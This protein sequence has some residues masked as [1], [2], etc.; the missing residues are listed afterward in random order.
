MTG[1]STNRRIWLVV[2]LCGLVLLAG[3]QGPSQLFGSSDEVSTERPT[4]QSP[5]TPT[6][7]ATPNQSTAETAPATPV[8]TT[9]PTR[10]DGNE[11]FDPSAFRTAFR[12]DIADARETRGVTPL[13]VAPEQRQVTDTIARELAEAGYF[14]NATAQNSSRFDVRSRL[15]RAELSCSAATADGQPVGGGFLL[16][17]FYRTYIETDGNITYYETESQLARSMTTR[18][19]TTNSTAETQALAATVYSP[20]AMTQSIGVYRTDTNAIYVVYAVC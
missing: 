10:N 8:T 20:E 4:T 1:E 12:E 18:V 5:V 11:S 17:G 14:E 6:S 9:T 3:C 15:N 19:L 13:T 2:A 7:T 16:K